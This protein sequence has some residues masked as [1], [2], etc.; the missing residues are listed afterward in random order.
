MI[1]VVFPGPGG[2]DDPQVVAGVSD[3]DADRAGHPAVADP[4]RPGSRAGYGDDG[5]RGDGAGPGPGQ[6][7]HRRVGGQ[8]GDRGQ[9]GHRQQIAAAEPA[10][11]DL[12]G[13]VAEVAAGQPVPPRVQGG[14]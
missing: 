12:F 11:G 1:R 2:A 13:G 8:A 7:G 14:R 9:L 6:A 4:Q 10:G 3:G 5:R